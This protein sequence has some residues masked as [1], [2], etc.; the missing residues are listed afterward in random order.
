MTSNEKECL[1]Q[2]TYSKEKEYLKQAAC[3][4]I[5]T[6][7]AYCSLIQKQINQSDG[8]F[9]QMQEIRESLR[10]LNHITIATERICRILHSAESDKT[11]EIRERLIC[12]KI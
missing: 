1:K 12:E 7:S 5:A 6:M 2:A 9:Q 8:S 4:T 3:S 10:A 11:P